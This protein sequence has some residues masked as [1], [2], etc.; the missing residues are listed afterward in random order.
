[1]TIESSSDLWVTAARADPLYRP[2]HLAMIVFT[3]VFAVLAGGLMVMGAVTA[4][5]LRRLLYPSASK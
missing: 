1:M 3:C 2:I 5:R 4:S